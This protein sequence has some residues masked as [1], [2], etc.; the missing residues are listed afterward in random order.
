M[1]P[2]DG[3]SYRVMAEPYSV[4]DG[5]KRLVFM[6]VKIDISKV[7]IETFE[8]TFDEFRYILLA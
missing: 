1:R 3:Q 4:F 8:K 6:D 5:V 7:L 2:Q